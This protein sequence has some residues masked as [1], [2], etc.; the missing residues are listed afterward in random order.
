MLLQS[1]Q[2]NNNWNKFLPHMVEFCA[3][4][5]QIHLQRNYHIFWKEIKAKILN[6]IEFNCILTV[7][8]TRRLNSLFQFLKYSLEKFIFLYVF[9]N[10]SIMSRMQYKIN[11]KQG[12][13]GLNSKF[14]FS[15]TSC[16][17]KIKEPS[18]LYYLPIAGERIVECIPFPK[19]S[20][21]S[22]MQ[23]T[24]SRIWT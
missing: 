13:T 11:F 21:L 24:S 22:K 2:N 15:K 9:T 14:S 16:Q 8:A 1:F 23:T 7:S 20:V 4:R 6:Q 10:T 19:I 3:D 5:V 12:L 17:S 18:L